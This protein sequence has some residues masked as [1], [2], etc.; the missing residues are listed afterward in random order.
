MR[1]V[2]GGTEGGVMW[3]RPGVGIGC[4]V[5]AVDCRHGIAKE[6]SAAERIDRSGLQVRDH[7]VLLLHTPQELRIVCLNFGYPRVVLVDQVRELDFRL[8]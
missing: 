1:G 2:E 4:I 7:L 5:Q 6:V 8:L 3:L